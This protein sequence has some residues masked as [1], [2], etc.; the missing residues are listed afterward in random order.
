MEQGRAGGG[1]LEAISLG[2]LFAS[3]QTL[4]RAP[5]LL[6]HTTIGLPALWLS[7]F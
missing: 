4:R 7:Y 3:L 2:Q 5:T 6:H 1:P